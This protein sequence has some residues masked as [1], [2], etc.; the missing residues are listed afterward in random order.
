VRRTIEDTLA[1]LGIAFSSWRNATNALIAVNIAVFLAMVAA[2]V[3]WIEPSGKD[4]LRWGAEYGPYTLS[5]QY[6]R[7]LT[8]SFVHIGILHLALNMWCL[9][10]LGRLL[11]KFLGPLVV[12][13]IY[14]VT[15]VGASL[16][17]LSWE[18][19]RV[20][21]GA[22][23]AIFGIA[24][25]LIAVL[26]CGKLNLPAENVRKL[27]G[28]VVRFSLLNLLYGLRGNINN[29]AHFGGL[30]T[31]LAAG[32]FL[33]RSFVLP[34]EQRGAQR[35]N[36]LVFAALA[37]VLLFIPV[38]NAKSYAGEMRKGLLA[39]DHKDFNSAIEHLK[40]YTAAQPNDAYGHAVLGSAL[41][42]GKRYDEAA[43]EYEW[44]L[45]LRPGYAFVQVNLGRVYLALDKPDKA[46][47]MFRA[48]I[49]RVDPDAD[50]FYWYA[51]ALKAT[52][53]LDGAE[54]AARQAINLDAKDVEAQSLLNEI[55][56]AEARTDGAAIDGKHTGLKRKNAKPAVSQ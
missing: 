35:R 32:I 4:L 11:E 1:P 55:L 33:A 48:G 43:R 42:G 20:G 56:E 10:S 27:L 46:I 30:V 44:A 45:R 29:M 50:N 17:S 5:G 25:T 51:V 36:V 14:L 54:K 9:W 38:S 8:P 31:G 39:F 2:G 15:G 40:K 21:A 19:M 53:D 34:E 28:Y 7:L 49:S 23:G 16:L 12:V 3:S 52:G 26:Y 6:W 47:Q 41:H 22:S 24:G 13:G 37:M 18:P